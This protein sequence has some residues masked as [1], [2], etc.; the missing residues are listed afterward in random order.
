MRKLRGGQN[1]ANLSQPFSGPKFDKFGRH[2]GESL[3]VDNFFPIVHI[4][5]FC[6]DMFGQNSKSVPKSVF[7]LSPWGVKC[8]GSS[9]QMFHT[10]V[11]SEYVTKFG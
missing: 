3:Y 10:T 1:L 11:I 5:F 4:V 2:V 9:D 8:P 7:A 6:R